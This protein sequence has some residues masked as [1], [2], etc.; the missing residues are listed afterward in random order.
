MRRLHFGHAKTIRTKIMGA[1]SVITIMIALVT[2]TICFS[3]FQSFL[4]N[5]QIQSAEFNLQIVSNHVS[6]DMKD[7]IYFS[8]WCCSNREI[9]SYL[10]VMKDQDNLAAA[11]RNDLQVR[12]TALSAFERLKEEYQSTKPSS[13][14]SA[15]ASSYIERVIVSTANT[16]NF[17]QIMMTSLGNS[18]EASKVVAESEFFEPVYTADTYLWNGLVQNPFVKSTDEP[19]IPLIRPVNDEFS[20]DQ[21]G[22]VYLAVSPD[23]ITDYLRAFPLEE[24]S[25]LFITIG[26]KVYAV[27]GHQLQE[28]NLDYVPQ[29]EYS[30]I[31]VNPETR[32]T[33]IKFSDGTVRTMVTFPL[34]VEGA[35]NW[36]IS[37]VLSHRQ[38]NQ[39]RQLYAGIVVVI[40]LIIITLGIVLGIYMNRTIS[41]PVGQVRLK[42]DRIAGGDFSL[43]P[44]I[45][46]E[47]EIGDIGRGINHLSQEIV[48]LMDRRVADEK[49]KKDLEYQILQSQINPHFLYNTLNSIKWMATIQNATGIAE[50]T[51]ALARLM[52]NISKGTT[53]L[54]SLREELELVNDY[55]LIQQYRYGGSVTLT[56]EIFD[57]DIYNCP[58]HR[59]S[60]QPIIENALFHGIEPKGCAGKIKIRADITDQNGRSELQ[61]SVT[62]NGIGMSPENI[63]QLLFGEA[64]PQAK[65]DF[66]KQVGIRNVNQ[67]IK[68]EFGEEYGIT[69]ESSPGEYTKMI[70]T[71]PYQSNV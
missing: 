13:Y 51:T 44:T 35:Q 30:G 49:Q 27:T 36:Y 37:Q 52:K 20:T 31:A 50:M 58:I 24:D 32:V 47:H 42:I 6:T 38:L 16:K 59:F 63:R 71:I 53:A 4:K 60:L 64:N 68:Y 11:S 7:I 41:Q 67:R 15:Y 22:F 3:I 69:I 2:V 48:S 19:V 43:D 34:P 40:C 55:F 9:L 17:L 61:L 66:F 54:I 23:I 46:W 18:S 26:D 10:T 1:T 25:R 14:T 39:Q 62:D 33:D 65:N 45:E 56:Y 5:N 28:V 29:Q 21:I 8:K 12:K 70:I 57:E